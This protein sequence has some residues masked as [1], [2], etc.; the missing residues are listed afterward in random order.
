MNKILSFLFLCFA[1]LV[2]RGT[3][4]GVASYYTIKS[5]GGTA[6]ASG[7]RLRDDLCTAAHRTLPFGT[8][9]KV[10]N[11][12]NNKTVVVRCNDRGPFI[13][14][15]IVDVSLAAAKVIDLQTSGIA[16]VKVEVVKKINK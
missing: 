10:T 8:L 6:T 4:Y 9:I 1:P 12:K 16:K 15:R 5:N 13:K 11:L 14:S 2:C 3:E 7:E